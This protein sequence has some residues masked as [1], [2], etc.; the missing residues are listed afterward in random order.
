MPTEFEKAHDAFTKEPSNYSAAELLNAALDDESDDLIDDDAFRDAIGDVR[1]YL[2]ETNRPM[3]ARYPVDQTLPPA[4]FAQLPGEGTAIVIKRGE[5][6]YGLAH[7]VPPFEADVTR[8]NNLLGVT[9]AQRQ[10]M[11]AGSMF[12]WDCKAAHAS[13]YEGKKRSGK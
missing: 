2:R 6:G 13:S 10:A 8:L 1:D 3:A 9:D 4:C 11:L 12:G 5:G 7:G